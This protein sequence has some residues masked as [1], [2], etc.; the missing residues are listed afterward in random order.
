MGSTRWD[1]ISLAPP[2]VCSLPVLNLPL[3]GQNQRFKTSKLRSHQKMGAFG[4]IWMHLLG[5][6]PDFEGKNGHFKIHPDT[7]EAQNLKGHQESL[8]NACGYVIE[9][10]VQSLWR[11]HRQAETARLCNLVDD[12]RSEECVAQVDSFVSKVV[13]IDR[14]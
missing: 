12:S 6:P 9:K 14:F 8:Q 2:I 10:A 13:Q 3:G 11:Q 4:C 5:N 7:W 1:R